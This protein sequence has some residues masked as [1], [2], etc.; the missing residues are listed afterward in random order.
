[1]YAYI[2]IPLGNPQSTILVRMTSVLKMD[3]IGNFR[4]GQKISPEAFFWWFLIVWNSRPNL[5]SRLQSEISAE[6]WKSRIFQFRLKFQTIGVRIYTYKSYKRYI[7]LALCCE[8]FLMTHMVYMAGIPRCC[9]PAN[10]LLVQAVVQNKT[11]SRR[12]D[13][14][15]FCFQDDLVEEEMGGNPKMRGKTP[16]KW[17]VEHNG[18]PDFLMG[19]FGGKTH[20]FRKHPNVWTC[21]TCH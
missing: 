10:P 15:N 13:A 1:M 18:K 9:K 3:R 17:M 4:P 20:Y 11:L 7:L 5:K 12:S 16:P 8:C 19:W 21:E 6:N 2:Y 14:R